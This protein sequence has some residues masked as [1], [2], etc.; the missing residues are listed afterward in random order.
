MPPFGSDGSKLDRQFGACAVLPTASSHPPCAAAP[1]RAIEP[2]VA[3]T[4][5]GVIPVDIGYAGGARSVLISVGS[6][7][8]RSASRFIASMLVRLADAR[9][10]TV[11]LVRTVTTCRAGVRSPLA[12]SA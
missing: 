4:A 10:A 12:G 1:D 2:A 6:G 11:D 3:D 9:A 8:D 7:D 5:L